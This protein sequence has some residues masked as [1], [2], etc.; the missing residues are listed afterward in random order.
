MFVRTKGTGEY[1]YLQIVENYRQDSRVKQRVLLTLG[2]KEQLVESGKL[3]NLAR[4][5]LRFSEKLRVVEAHR[6]GGLKAR[7][8]Q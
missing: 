8:T 4:S 2:R 6:N 5:L 1:K 7:S 3:D